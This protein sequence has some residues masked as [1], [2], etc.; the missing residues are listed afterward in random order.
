MDQQQ[1]NIQAIVQRMI[2]AGEPEDAIASVI[3]HYKTQPPEPDQKSVGGFLSNI[4]SSAKDLVVNTVKGLPTLAK[5]AI[6]TVRAG[7]GDPGAIGAG[8]A[9]LPQIASGAKDYATER[10]GSFD[11]IKDTLYRD[12]VGAVAD[13]STLAGGGAALPGRVGR[14]ATRVERATNPIRPLA[15]G[16][17]TATEV[18]AAALV[19]PSLNPPKALRRQQH[20]PLELERTAIRGGIVTRGQARRRARS[21]AA[22]TTAKAQ[23]ATDAGITVPRGDVAQFPDTLKRVEAMTPNVRPLDELAGLESETV[24]TLGPQLTPTELLERRRSLDSDLN[25]AFR[26][27]EQPGGQPVSIREEG[28]QELVGNIRDRLREVAPDVRQSDDAARRYGSVEHALEEAASRPSRLTTM[29]AGGGAGAFAL[30]GN[31]V[32]AAVSTALGAG[33]QFPQIPLALGI[34][35]AA[36]TRLMSMEP[37]VRAALLARLAGD[38]R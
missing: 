27:A 29:A 4:G 24:A 25:K 14:I 7:L 31:P 28:Q 30:S 6:H 11:K 38:D 32:G 18:G 26:R 37:S 23:A 8:V 20:G 16:A 9:A 15:K 17:A 5:G 35:P 12:P 21:S 34:P 36:L 10:Y 2:D 13:V 1:P 22:Q 33:L 3:Q 19:R